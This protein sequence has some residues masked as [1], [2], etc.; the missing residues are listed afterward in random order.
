MQTN[1]ALSSSS[2]PLTGKTIVVTRAAGQSSQFTQVLASFGANV[3][4][5][6][7]LEI[8]PPSSW[9]GLDNAI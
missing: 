1:L 8:G 5:M 2:R 4:E 3:I 9:E 6:P 7:T